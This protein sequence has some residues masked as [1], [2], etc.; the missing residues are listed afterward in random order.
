M[1]ART[2]ARELSLIGISQIS[3]SLSEGTRRSRRDTRT[4]EPATLN[5]QLTDNPAPEQID[6]FLR[7]VLATLGNDA[8]EMIETAEGELQRAERLMLE[9][10]TRTVESDEVRDRILPA[11][12][13]VEAAI[14]RIG[15]LFEQLMFVQQQN[16]K[17]MI[18]AKEA[19]QKAA[20]SIEAADRLMENHEQ[21][22]VD[23]GVVRSQ[24]ADAISTVKT[25][26]VGVKKAL[27]PEHLSKLISQENIRT[28]ANTLFYNWVRYWRD[29]DIQLDDAMEKWNVRR[30]ARVDRDILRLAMIEIVHMDVPIKVAID[31]AVEMA[32]RYSDEEGYRFINGVLRRTTD[33]LETA[34]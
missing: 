4:S 12:P 2:I 5:Q 26:L 20:N 6:A 13:L 11:I 24:I 16:R 17:D 15:G 14:N 32:K 30:L 1:K 7:K 33:K 19:L 8:Q 3:D 31:E 9:S 23:I 27:V 28:Y 29:I 18:A 22:I 10:E 34:E 21:K 25:A